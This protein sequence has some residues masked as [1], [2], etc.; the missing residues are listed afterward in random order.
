MPALSIAL[1]R[2]SMV[3]TRRARVFPVAGFVLTVQE[4]EAAR[5]AKASI[6]V[7]SGCM[8]FD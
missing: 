3:G 2:A 5:G 7:W 1:I 4:E 6:S 8:D